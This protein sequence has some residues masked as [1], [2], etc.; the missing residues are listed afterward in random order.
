MPTFFF[1]D[2]IF[3]YKIAIRETGKNL[4]KN[5]KIELETTKGS[6]LTTCYC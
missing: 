4:K 2:V 3:I 1:N 5:V 6:T